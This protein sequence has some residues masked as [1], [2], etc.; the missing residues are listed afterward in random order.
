LAAQHHQRE[1]PL[2]PGDAGGHQRRRFPGHQKHGPHHMVHHGGSRPRREV[3]FFVGLTGLCSSSS[4][5]LEP[6][7]GLP[8][9]SGLPRVDGLGRGPQRPADSSWPG[10][11]PPRRC[12]T[13]AT[14]P[15]W[16]PPCSTRAT[17]RRPRRTPW[18]TDTT[19]RTPSASCQKVT[20]PS[21]AATAATRL[22]TRAGDALELAVVS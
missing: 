1:P 2:L 9:H 16:E 13:R 3:A 14:T 7:A 15:W 6:H 17:C 20:G 18:G 11:L 5:H 10:S 12:P 22:C 8:Q 4:G 21:V 19:T